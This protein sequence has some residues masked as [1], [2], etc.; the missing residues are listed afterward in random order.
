MDSRTVQEQ[1][2]HTDIRTTPIYTHVVGRGG[3]SVRSPLDG[4]LATARGPGP[5]P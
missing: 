3:A 2:G 1:L 5:A 4:V